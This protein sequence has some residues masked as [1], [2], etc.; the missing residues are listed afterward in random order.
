MVPK[1]A[2]AIPET[3]IHEV[4]ELLNNSINLLQPY[5]IALTPHELRSM[6]K[7]SDKS[8]PFVE[9]TRDYTQA[10]PQ[11]IPLYMDAEQLQT[12]LA[13]FEDLTGLLRISKQLTSGLDDS[14]M[15]AGANG[16]TRAL[17]YY[18]SVKQAAKMG[19]P[20]AK[21]IHEDLS[22]RFSKNRTERE[23]TQNTTDQ[24]I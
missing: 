11:F 19:V 18:N 23:E 21:G 7:M 3:V 10:S 20:G 12:D 14:A 8:L 6:P 17:S 15:Q 4:T 16:F 1:S 24:Q 9:K 5:L 2:L 13:V 22:K